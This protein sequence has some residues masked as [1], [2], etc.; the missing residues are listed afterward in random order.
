MYVCIY[1]TCDSCTSAYLLYFPLFLQ[2]RAIH[3]R[4]TVIWHQGVSWDTIC[5]LSMCVS[6]SISSHDFMIVHWV[7]R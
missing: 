3:S 7:S 5:I 1:L 2:A 4:C 6:V